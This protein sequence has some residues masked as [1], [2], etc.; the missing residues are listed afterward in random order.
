[1]NLTDSLNDKLLIQ[2]AAGQGCQ[3]QSTGETQF[4]KDPLEGRMHVCVCVCVCRKGIRLNQADG[5][6]VQTIRYAK[7]TAE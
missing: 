6:Y 2:L 7:R 4:V 5:C 1:V 3:C